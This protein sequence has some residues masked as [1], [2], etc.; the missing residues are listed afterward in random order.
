[1]KQ[2]PSFPDKN[3]KLP[4]DKSYQEKKIYEVEY[5]VVIKDKTKWVSPFL[6]EQYFTWRP[7][8]KYS[9]E[10]KRNQAVI[11]LNKNNYHNWNYYW[12]YRAKQ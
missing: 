4:K 12:E 7:F 5:R 3:R 11:Q 8:K 6:I 1:M 9:T 2:Q 10:K